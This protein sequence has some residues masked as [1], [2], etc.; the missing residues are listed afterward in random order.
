MESLGTRLLKKV[1]QTDLVGFR[2]SG[3]IVKSAS[4][5]VLGP[6]SAANSCTSAA[7]SCNDNVVPFADAVWMLK[8]ARDRVHQR[9]VAQQL[10]ERVGGHGAFREL[11]VQQYEKLAAFRSTA[12]RPL[13]I[14]LLYTSP[15][16]RDQ[17]G[18]RMPSSA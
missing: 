13:W 3:Q 4:E 5:S 17:R 12:W 15:S 1:A 16:P 8:A 14:C 18:S 7:N 6:S 11:R 9:I 2:N 10:M